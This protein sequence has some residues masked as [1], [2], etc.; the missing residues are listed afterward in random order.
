MKR[1]Y[2]ISGVILLS[3]LIFLTRSCK[4]DEVP[5]LTTS[6]VTNI[7]GTSATS[8][9]IITSEGSGS[10]IARGVCWSTGNAPTIADSK[11]TDG[12]GG[13]SFQ[14]SMS[15]LNGASVYNVRAYATNSVGTGYGTAISFTTTFTGIKGTVSDNDGNTYQTIG[16]GYQIWMAENLKTTKYNDAASIPLVTDGTAW[17]NLVT[18]GYCWYNND[19]AG[20]KAI[21]GALYNWY[22]VNTGKLCPS[23][24]HIP[25]DNEWTTLTTFLGGESVAGG[26]LKEAGTTHWTTPN[27]AATNETGFTALPAGYRLYNGQYLDIGNTGVWWSPTEFSTTYS[28]DWN[29]YY[30]SASVGSGNYDKQ[31]GFSVRCLKDK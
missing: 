27:T 17:T 20:Y 4:K 15:G 19:A 30:S 12:T 11:T 13:G 16:I 18:P 21:Y 1:I 10:V 28:W 7:T 23:G 26:K 31:S 9:G 29:L 3:L 24:W 25:T 8:G 5:A 22:T 2:Q 14:S 6:A